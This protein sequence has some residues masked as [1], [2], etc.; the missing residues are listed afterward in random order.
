MRNDVHGAKLLPQSK[1]ISFFVSDRPRQLA[2]RNSNRPF[3]CHLDVP[4]QPAIPQFSIRQ[5][6]HRRMI[7]TCRNRAVQL[8]GRV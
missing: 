2:R 5:L 3:A 8:F 1:K 6:S 7:G 4:A